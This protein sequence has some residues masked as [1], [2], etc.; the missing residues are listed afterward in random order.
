MVEV[1]QD[2]GERVRL[3]GGGGKQ[4]SGSADTACVVEAAWAR[5]GSV[6]G[7]FGVTARLCTS[8]PVGACRL[9]D[10]ILTEPFLAVI[11]RTSKY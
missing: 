10:G 6:G 4:R 1:R 5:V 2:A 3:A 9:P 8:G 11:D 7:C